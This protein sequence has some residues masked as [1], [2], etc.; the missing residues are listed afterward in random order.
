MRKMWA[1]H[2][3]LLCF[4]NRNAGILQ[5]RLNLKLAWSFCSGTGAQMNA[6]N[7]G[8]IEQ[9]VLFFQHQSTKVLG[10][11]KQN[12]G[13]M[14]AKSH[15]T[16]TFGI[17]KI[18]NAAGSRKWQFTTRVRSWAQHVNW[19]KEAL[20]STHLQTCKRSKDTHWAYKEN[21]EWRIKT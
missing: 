6:W 9:I 21:V 3:K 8:K 16:K 7:A 13:L 4:V 20:H 11:M 18:T 19:N 17:H 5:F 10:S 15:L 14:E 1:S 2:R 12:I